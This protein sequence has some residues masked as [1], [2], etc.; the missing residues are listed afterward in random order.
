MKR[1]SWTIFSD[2]I[3]QMDALEIRTMSHVFDAEE[4][5]FMFWA[6]VLSLLCTRFILAFYQLSSVCKM[7][8]YS[9]R[10]PRYPIAL[11][12]RVPFKLSLRERGWWHVNA[13]TKM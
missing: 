12:V 7:Q 4:P 11:V 3:K 9:D 6:T 5:H 8:S 10:G 13:V 1:F 2:L